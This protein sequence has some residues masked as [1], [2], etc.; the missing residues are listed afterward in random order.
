MFVKLQVCVYFFAYICI[1][2]SVCVVADLQSV[3]QCAAER[4]TVL[5]CK[6]DCT[7]AQGCLFQC[8]GAL[9]EG[10]FTKYI[11]DQCGGIN[12]CSGGPPPPP[13]PSPPPLPRP[14]PAP[15]SS[16]SGG[17]SLTLMVNVHGLVLGMSFFASMWMVEWL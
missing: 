10:S 7:F 1:G 8:Q 9:A 12:I 14:P 13:S 11:Y 17:P 15:G 6:G 16:G 4:A 5:A 3:T 2:S